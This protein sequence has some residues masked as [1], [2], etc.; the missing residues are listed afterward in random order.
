MIERRNFLKLAGALALAPL[1]P[2]LPKKPTERIKVDCGS[3]MLD[4]EVKM[5]PPW[6]RFHPSYMSISNP[7]TKPI[8]IHYNGRTKTLPPGTIITQ[9]MKLDRKFNRVTTITMEKIK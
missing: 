4:V 5:I 8:K 1:A 9:T 3:G 7:S 2:F 6:T